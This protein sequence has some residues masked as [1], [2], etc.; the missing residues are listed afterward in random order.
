QVASD[1]EIRGAPDLILQSSVLQPTILWNT[2]STRHKTANHAE[3][4]NTSA[5]S[6]SYRFN[7]HALETG[8]GQ[9]ST[10]PLS[11]DD[12]LF[13]DP[14]VALPSTPGTDQQ[15]ESSCKTATKNSV[16]LAE[17]SA[18]TSDAVD[19]SNDRMLRDTSNA[20]IKSNN[21]T[22]EP[23][24]NG[25]LTFVNSSLPSECIDQLENAS[26]RYKTSKT[27]ASSAKHMSTSARKTEIQTASPATNA[28]A[29][30]DES[31]TPPLPA[32]KLEQ[33]AD[34][35][36]LASTFSHLSIG[37]TTTTNCEDELTPLDGSDVGVPVY[38]LSITEKRL[39]VFEPSRERWI[40]SVRK[41]DDRCPFIDDQIYIFDAITFDRKAKLAKNNRIRRRHYLERDEF[42]YTTERAYRLLILPG[43]LLGSRVRD[44]EQRSAT[45][46]KMDLDI[47]LIMP[48]QNHWLE[49]VDLKTIT[50]VQFMLY[51]FDMYPGKGGKSIV[52]C[53]PPLTELPEEVYDGANLEVMNA[54]I[55]LP[56]V[57]DALLYTAEIEKP[58]ANWN[59]ISSIYGTRG[60]SENDE[61]P[62]QKLEST[63]FQYA[64][65]KGSIELN[66]EQQEAVARYAAVPDTCRASMVEAPPGSGKTVTAAAMALSYKGEGIQLFVSTANV[67]V[68]NMAL[69]FAKLDLGEM[70]ALH[71]ISSEREEMT[72]EETRSPFS[73]LALAKK[74]DH[75]KEAIYKLEDE[76]YYAGTEKEKAIIRDRI[77]RICLPIYDKHYDVYLGT[78]DTIL[79]RLFKKNT[80]YVKHQLMKKVR[81]IVVDE[82]SQLTEAALNALILS[83]PRAQIV[84]I[85][86][87][88]QMPPFKYNKGEVVSELAARSAL[89]VCKAK[90]N[91][92]VT[93]LTHVYRASQKLI[94]HYSD[95]FYEGSLKSCKP[96]SSVNPLSCFGSSSGGHRCL[97]WE[98]QG[99]Q[100]QDGTSVVNEG[101]IATLKH[102]V[103]KLLKTGLKK[104]DV[105]IISYYEA[106]RKKAEEELSEGYEVLT[107]DS[108][109][110]REKKVV[111]V[112][113]T[114]SSLP[115]DNGS[116][117]LCP[118]RCNVAVSRHQE[119]LIVLG[120]KATA[121]APNW[122][123]ILSP[124]YF[125][126]V[127]PLIF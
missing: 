73:A 64:N 60:K 38:I 80:D 47:V 120:H 52:K 114:R 54:V 81:R 77:Y 94:A 39:C 42:A 3:T 8:E 105:M 96:E 7:D 12:L 58:I 35:D 51:V 68:I 75:L 121:S 43:L 72:T 41:A 34:V 122:A 46:V 71:F 14:T 2:A 100:S 26:A 5:P 109:Q 40:E 127:E 99:N 123:E 90:R 28:T 93:T 21:A 85:G 23:R 83:F 124:K 49:E 66:E 84:L 4:A 61:K 119:A 126:H 82:A 95:V 27:L 31:S 69:A 45:V 10:R 33:A 56:R 16:I 62:V 92:P 107:V 108:A 29:L 103:R 63:C 116:F 78:V 48:A 59:L 74:N 37:K 97:F 106:Q 17:A 98:A 20:S 112:L 19:V 44:F 104:K 111:I 91:L 88:N 55:E 6:T 113:T 67:P 18:G 117:F 32:P 118:L 86:D 13:F 11:V 9:E 15:P 53:H 50:G 36:Q 30:D 79:G 87:S 1:G 76:L 70:K 102:I 115:T 110:G 22:K 24:K 89:D 65:G 125:K 57:T 101:E 25:L